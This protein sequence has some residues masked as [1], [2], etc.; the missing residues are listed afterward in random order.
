MVD[1]S[2]EKWDKG[3]ILVIILKC[4]GF[5]IGLFFK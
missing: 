2:I 5:V 4:Y 3:D 1:R